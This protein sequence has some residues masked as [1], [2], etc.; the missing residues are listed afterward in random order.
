VR[1]L[2]ILLMA[3]HCGSDAAEVLPISTNGTRTVLL[4]SNCKTIGK[5][6][7]VIAQPD[8]QIINHGC[9]IIKNGWIVM[10]LH[11]SKYL[12]YYPK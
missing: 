6:F 8:Q 7:V 5:Q 2:F 12:T 9:W 11:N 10:Q 4:N 1:K 3:L